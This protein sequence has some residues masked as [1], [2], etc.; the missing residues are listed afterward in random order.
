LEDVRFL[1][2][3]L[4]IETAEQAMNVVTRYFDEPQIPLKTRL[5]LEELLGG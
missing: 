1:L 2:R 4:D 3:Y 5:A